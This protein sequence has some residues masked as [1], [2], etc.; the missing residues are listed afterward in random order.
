VQF[1]K[2]VKQVDENVSE[3]NLFEKNIKLTENLVLRTLKFPNNKTQTNIK[4]IQ[5]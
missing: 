4:Y 3:V 1:G 2:A 5:I